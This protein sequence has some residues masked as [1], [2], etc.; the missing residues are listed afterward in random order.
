MTDEEIKETRDYLNENVGAFLQ[1]DR[2]TQNGH[3]SGGYPSYICPVCGSGSGKNGTGIMTKDGRH[4]TCFSGRCSGDVRNVDGVDLYGLSRGISGFIQIL[5]AAR[6]EFGINDG[7]LMRAAAE[8][9]KGPEKKKEERA[10]HNFISYYKRCAA[11][12][13]KTNYMQRRGISMETC[14]RYLVGYDSGWVSPNLSRRAA[15]YV[16]PTPRIIIPVS[17]ASYLARDIRVNLSDSSEKYKKMKVGKSTIYNSACLNNI[18]NH[19]LV[20]VEGEIDCL[21]V[22]EAGYPFCIGMGSTSNIEQ[23]VALLSEKRP[24]DVVIALDSDDAGCQAS[25]RL[26]AR[27]L[28]SGIAA[29]VCDINCGE[30]DANDALVKHREEFKSK[31]RTFFAPGFDGAPPHS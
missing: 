29:R 3:L 18:G 2:E 30:N 24:D 1:E 9:A 4:Y 8:R 14:R 23:V 28:V 27:L 6:E 17:S 5:K 20:I 31:V 11:D 21:S 13:E 22:I 26:L 15:C 12:I 25:G 19:A 7:H 16:K 10:E